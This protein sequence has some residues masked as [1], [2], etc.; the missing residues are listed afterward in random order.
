MFHK[1]NSS[2]ISS[3]NIMDNFN[4][5]VTSIDKGTTQISFE[6]LEKKE[7]KRKAKR[8]KSINPKY[9]SNQ[10]LKQLSS[11]ETPKKKKS[12]NGKGKSVKFRITNY[13]ES[14][15]PE[16]EDELNSETTNKDNILEN[17]LTK[18]YSTHVNHEKR[19]SKKALI[20]LKLPSKLKK[21]IDLLSLDIVY[22]VENRYGLFDRY[23]QD[24][25]DSL[26]Q[27]SKLSF[28]SVFS[29]DNVKNVNYYIHEPTYDE[30]GNK[31]KL[32][33]LDLDET[34]IHSEIRNKNNFNI[35][36]KVKDSANC[37]HKVFSYINNNFLYYLD[38]FFRPHL[39][40]FLHEI[41][42]YFDIGIF[43]ASSQGYADTIINYIDPFNTIFKFRLY[44]D[45]CIPIQNAI[46][47]KDLRIIRNYEPSNVILL[48][49][50]LYSFINQQKNGMLIYSFYWDN[51]DDQLIKAKN[52]LIKYIYNAND[53]REEI[54]KW[55]S[56]NEFR[57]K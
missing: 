54:D 28:N 34:L 37:Y 1:N 14:V 16:E 9:F 24:I 13:E 21:E 40:D 26:K 3:L 52:F 2:E 55:Y 43:T 29:L 20:H 44:R 7:R 48:D 57:K 36:N 51:K 10:N 45:A 18:A 49:N 25:K 39:F 15:I 41:Q 35:L 12:R 30:K 19:R 32:L 46:Y 38:I 53:V 22:P 33:L 42:N 11:K 5:L 56:Y 27:I 6:N 47:I 31:K 23:H 17:M 4:F 8:N 50:S